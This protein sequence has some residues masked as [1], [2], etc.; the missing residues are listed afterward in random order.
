MSSSAALLQCPGRVTQEED[1]GQEVR[2][3]ETKTEEQMMIEED[4]GLDLL[5]ARQ[6]LVGSLLDHLQV[7][8]PEVRREKFRSNQLGLPLGMSSQLRGRDQHHQDRRPKF[9]GNQIHPGDL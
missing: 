8:H 3:T 7:K 9:L 1:L 4:R 6:K 2:E 5:A